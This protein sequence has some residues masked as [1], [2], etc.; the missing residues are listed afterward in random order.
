[1]ALVLVLSL[2]QE[3]T[4]QR[5]EGNGVRLDDTLVDGDLTDGE[6][7]AAYLVLVVQLVEQIIE[8]SSLVL[9]LP[10]ESLHQ[11]KLQLDP[12]VHSHLHNVVVSG[13]GC[14][15]H[16]LKQLQGVA[17]VMGGN[18]DDFVVLAERGK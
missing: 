4:G 14:H 8:R 12:E 15:L 11:I 10:P 18:Q 7:V 2:H 13:S 9:L 5:R 17:L 3:R 1:V 16:Q 6:V